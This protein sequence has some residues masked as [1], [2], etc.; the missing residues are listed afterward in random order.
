[1]DNHAYMRSRSELEAQEWT[2]GD[3]VILKRVPVDLPLNLADWFDPKTL[4]CWIDGEVDK[5]E[6]AESPL[7]LQPPGARSRILATLL[8]YAFATQHL[9]LVEILRACRDTEPFQSLVGEHQPYPREVDHFRRLNRSLL[10][11][12]LANVYLMALASKFGVPV[13]HLPPAVCRDVRMRAQERLDI[14]R[15]LSTWD[16]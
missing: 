5:A 8:V 3:T 16:E 1:M 12:I 6:L 7:G 14:A 2:S 15:H 9:E 4:L 11:E 10:E 13:D